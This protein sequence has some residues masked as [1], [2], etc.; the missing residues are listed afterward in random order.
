MNDRK[1]Q[2]FIMPYAGGSSYSFNKLLRYI[3]SKIDVV[4]VEYPGRG[5]RA[6][7]KLVDS[8]EDLLIDSME[9]AS[10]K[11]NMLMPYAIMGYSMGSILAYE[12]LRSGVLGE[13]VSHTFI[14]A[15]VSPIECSLEFSREGN[16]TDEAIIEKAREKG[17]VDDRLLYNK[18]FYDIYVYPVVSDYKLLYE[19]RYCEKGEPVVS[20]TTFFY[21][22]NDTSQKRLLEW[23]KLIEGEF[24]FY[25]Y[26]GGHFFMNQYYR[27]MASVINKKLLGHIE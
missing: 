14:C 15:Q 26:K 24:D 12:L 16:L 4:I 25:E 20:N 11:R 10:V 19:Y 18:R 13:K 23:N 6:N 17:C 7:E 21:C 3:D 8:F 9:Y 22:E 27:E 5:T 2:L 1:I